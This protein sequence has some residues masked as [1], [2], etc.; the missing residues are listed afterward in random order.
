MATEDPTRSSAEA[1]ASADLRMERVVLAFLL[2]EH[3]TRLTV[4]ELAFALDAK[5]FAEKDAIARAVREL[6]VVGLLRI[7][8]E[9]IA[10][11]RAAL[12]FH[13][14]EEA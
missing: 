5:D 8:G 9:L 12:R 10:A 11:T 3:P 13:A 7:D 4:R 14:L 2:N 6:T 1:P